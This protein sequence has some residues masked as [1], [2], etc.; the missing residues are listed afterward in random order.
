MND[1]II[2]NIDHSRFDLEWAKRGGRLICEHEGGERTLGV[3][4]LTGDSIETGTLLFGVIPIWQENQQWIARMATPA[5]C[6]AAG[7][8]RKDMG[9]GPV[10]IAIDVS[11]LSA[12][13]KVAKTG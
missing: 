6:E 11:Y 2:N 12:I 10:S 9:A 7:K 4:S 8:W 5:E 3:L 1:L 13:L